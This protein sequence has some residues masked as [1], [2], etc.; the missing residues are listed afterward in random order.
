[1]TSEVLDRM[2]I[3]VV[4]LSVC[5]G[6]VALLAI[7]ASM[8]SPRL[9]VAP[10][11]TDRPGYTYTCYCYRDSVRVEILPTNQPRRRHARS[12]P[13]RPR[14]RSRPMSSPNAGVAGG[15][16]EHAPVPVAA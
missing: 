3:G 2:V 16:G 12:E 13:A 11:P 14:N 10:A 6:L 5:L 1:M 9:A 4:C 8:P 7:Y 15:R